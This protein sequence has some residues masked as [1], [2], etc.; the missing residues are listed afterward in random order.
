MFIRKEN[1]KIIC[2]HLFN[3][4][5]IWAKKNLFLPRHPEVGVPNIEVIKLMKSF[6]S[7]EYVVE[8]FNWQTY[9]WR[10]TNDVCFKYSFIKNIHHLKYSLVS[11]LIIYYYHYLGT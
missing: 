11:I 9:Y 8:N 2:E 6:R 4:G 3:Q 10:L 1:K 5:V 7:K